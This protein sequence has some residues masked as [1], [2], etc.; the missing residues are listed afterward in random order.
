MTNTIDEISTLV[1]IYDASLSDAQLKIYIE[2]LSDIDPGA[3][4][5]GI[6]EIIKTSK[7]MPKVSEIRDAARASME[8][9]ES[10]LVLDWHDGRNKTNWH[11][12]MAWDFEGGARRPVELDWHICPECGVKYANW[13]TCPDCSNVEVKQL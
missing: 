5:L 3:L 4:H 1:M 9:Q 11:N 10:Q 13:D 7:W 2:A 12:V 6:V 8:S